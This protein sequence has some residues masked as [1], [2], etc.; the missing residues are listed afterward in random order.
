MK[1]FDINF[2]LVLG[3]QLISLLGG[4]MLRFAILLYILDLSNSPAIFATAMSVTMIPVFIFAIPGGILA[5]RLDKKKLI[6]ILDA[7]KAVICIYILIIFTTNSYT[8][9]NLTL[10]VS[11]FVAILNLFA[12]I[13]TAATPQIVDEKILP[14]ANGAIQSVNA[15]SELLSFVLG[16]FLVATVGIQNVIIIAMIAFMLS[17]IMDLY[18]K[19]DYKKQISQHGVIKTA[20]LDLKDA[21]NYSLKVNPQISI[22]TLFIACFVFL[23]MPLMLVAFPYIN[24]IHFEANEMMFGIS[25]ALSALGMLLGGVLAGFLKNLLI[26]SN[27]PKMTILV[28]IICLLTAITISPFMNNL[29]QLSFWLFNLGIMILMVFTTF[30]NVIAFSF[31]QENVP[32]TYVGKVVALMITVINIVNPLSQAIF[33]FIM[34]NVIGGNMSLFIIIGSL[35]VVLAILT[36]NMFKIKLI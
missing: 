25:Q 16:G 13:F 36:R 3:S 5:D 34:A 8:I 11:I 22:I 30:G 23:L 2:K 26:T 7:I 21:T 31:L 18:I 12:P 28:A 29:M 19:I 35:L 17:T 33:G 27:F 15:V 10:I 4:N 1:N 14:E 24:R 6:V 32:I 20:L 9:V